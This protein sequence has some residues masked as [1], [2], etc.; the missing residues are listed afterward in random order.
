[1][2]QSAVDERWWANVF[3]YLSV[4]C[5]NRMLSWVGVRQNQPLWTQQSPTCILDSACRS[6]REF[7]SQH[8]GHVTRYLYFPEF[9]TMTHLPRFPRRWW[10]QISHKRLTSLDNPTRSFCIFFVFFNKEAV[11]SSCLSR[12][13]QKGYSWNCYLKNQ[14]AAGEKEAGASARFLAR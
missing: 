11:V 4:W 6:G 13:I 9:S 8:K 7:Q 5:C 14:P 12:L 1:M 2:L 3:S 10:N